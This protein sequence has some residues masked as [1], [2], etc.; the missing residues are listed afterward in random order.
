MFT[1]FLI[2]SLWYICQSLILH[3]VSVLELDCFWLFSCFLTTLWCSI[4]LY[5]YI[6]GCLQNNISWFMVLSI[7]QFILT[8]SISLGFDFR[9]NFLM[10]YF[11]L[12]FSKVWVIFLLL[13]EFNLLFIYSS[14]FL[15]K[16]GSSLCSIFHMQYSNN[17]LGSRFQVCL[18]V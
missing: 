17:S 2:F 4:G 1:S 5:H 18:I 9:Y 16:T 8:Y 14:S 3:K 10:A 11:V 13:K 7:V 6:L 12:L 15:Q